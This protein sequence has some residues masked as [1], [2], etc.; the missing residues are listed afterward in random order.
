MLLYILA[1]QLRQRMFFSTI[2]RIKEHTEKASI[3]THK[4]GQQSS[5]TA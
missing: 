5:M 1:F 4:N 2:V 3:K